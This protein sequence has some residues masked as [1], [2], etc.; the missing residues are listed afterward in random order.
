[1]RAL[2]KGLHRNLYKTFN[3][4]FISPYVKMYPT[5]KRIAIKDLM[6]RLQFL[7]SLI[8]ATCA[9]DQSRILRKAKL[10]SGYPSL[11]DC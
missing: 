8:T 1:M 9:F 7:F 3:A 2:A 6:S 10:Y 4:V 5:K 11:D